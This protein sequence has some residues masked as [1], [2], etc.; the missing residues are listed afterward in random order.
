MLRQLFQ[1]YCC[2][3]YGSQLWNLSRP[4][5]NDKCTAWNKAARRIFHLPFST[6]RFLRPCVTQSE[7]IRDNLI[8]ISTTL[9]QN[10]MFS[11]NEVIK[12][13]S[14][15]AYFCNSPVG[16]NRK[17]FNVYQKRHWVKRRKAS[18]VYCCLYLKHVYST[19][20]HWRNQPNGLPRMYLVN[21]NNNAWVIVHMYLFI[22]SFGWTPT[23]IFFCFMHCWDLDVRISYWIEFVPALTIQH[24]MPCM[25]STEPL[26]IYMLPG[27]LREEAWPDPGPLPLVSK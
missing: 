26:E 21:M 19:I 4:S 13:L 15:N 8:K 16:L 27:Q 22:D 10:M 11:D 9:L 1:I 3:F 2:S 20:W 12:F 25:N 23:C 7:H 24:I 5:F 17:F 18:V 6:H 14:V